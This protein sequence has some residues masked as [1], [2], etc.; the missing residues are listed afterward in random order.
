MTRIQAF[1]A[2]LDIPA[3]R[4]RHGNVM[5]TSSIWLSRRP[6]LA[7]VSTVFPSSGD[8]GDVGRMNRMRM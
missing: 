6:L 7:S 4:L 3:Q 2:C 1:M 5:T 8:D